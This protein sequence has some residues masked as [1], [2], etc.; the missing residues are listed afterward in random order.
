MQSIYGIAVSEDGS[1]KGEPALFTDEPLAYILGTGAEWSYSLD[2]SLL[3]WEQHKGADELRAGV[4]ITDLT[5]GETTQLSSTGGRPSV[6]GN[7]V[8]YF[9]EALEAYDVTDKKTRTIDPLGDWAVSSENFVVYRRGVRRQTY[10]EIVARR[11]DDDTEQVL[12]RLEAHPLAAAPL[13]ASANHIAFVGDDGR[14][15][16]FEWRAGS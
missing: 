11:F 13:A 7:I 16:L 9:G 6:A 8:T 14:V 3:A 10:R 4:Y 2:G 1:P 12:A 15:K 5:S